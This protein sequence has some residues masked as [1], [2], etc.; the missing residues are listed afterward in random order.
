VIA[1]LRTAACVLDASELLA[2]C[3]G[4]G[5]TTS[6]AKSGTTSGAT[7]IESAPAGTVVEGTHVL[8]V[9]DV[10]E[11]EFKLDPAS[12]RFERFGYY[13]IRAIN[14]GTVPHALAIAGH[15]LA[16]RTKESAPGKSET[17][18]VLFSKAVRYV[19]TCPSDGHAQKGMT[20]TVRVH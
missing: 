8:A 11:T 6:T 2:G 3:G 13:G 12:I 18:L 17:M 20:A 10:H 16:K 14:D 19:L 15:G 7:S 5:T 1:V 4:G 9:V